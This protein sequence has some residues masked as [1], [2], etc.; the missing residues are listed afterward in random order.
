MDQKRNGTSEYVDLRIEVFCHSLKHEHIGEKYGDL[1]INFQV[2]F[3]NNP[4]HTVQNINP[5]QICEISLVYNRK[6]VLEVA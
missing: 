2:V 5:L 4:Q 6:H 1:A 3:P